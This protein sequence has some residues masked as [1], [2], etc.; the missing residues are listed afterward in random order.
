[1]TR[2]IKYHTSTTF[3]WHTLKP[4]ILF[5][6]KISF[7]YLYKIDKIGFNMIFLVNTFFNMIEQITNKKNKT[8]VII[9]NLW[10][11]ILQ[12]ETQVINEIRKNKNQNIPP[13]IAMKELSC[14]DSSKLSLSLCVYG[15]SDEINSKTKY[16]CY[17]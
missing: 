8:Q 9:F 16:M 17:I 10:C 7:L 3:F 6:N 13:G 5:K 12:N 14:F 1:M 11:Y 2:L 15:V 4:P